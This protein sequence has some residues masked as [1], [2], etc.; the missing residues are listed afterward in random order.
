MRKNLLRLLAAAL[1]GALLS[2]ALFG[3]APAGDTQS[4]PQPSAAPAKP[5]AGPEQTAAPQPETPQQAEPSQAVAGRLAPP[6]SRAAA[7]ADVAP[8]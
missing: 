4:L 8:P 3:C 1:A 6:R 2:A 5:S 7:G